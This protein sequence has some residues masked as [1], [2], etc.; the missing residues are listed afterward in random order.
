MYFYGEV[1]KLASI[2]YVPGRGGHGLSLVERWAAKRHRRCSEAL[3][4]S[5]QMR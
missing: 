4:Q 1:E 2:R 5:M 3:V